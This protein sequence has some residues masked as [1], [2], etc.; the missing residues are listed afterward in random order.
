M[1]IQK[2]SPSLINKIAAGEVVERPASVVKELMEN[3]L[4]A[5]ATR[6]DVAVV[7]GGLE[8]VRV[9]DNGG[10]IA[11]A[12]MPLAV[13]P[14]ATSKLPGEEDLF[15]VRTLG[16]RGE[17]L[18]SIAEVSR[19]VLRSRTPHHDG[20]GELE[21][22]GGQVGQVVPCGCPVG[23]SVEVHN[24]FYNTPVRR[25]FLRT[26]QTEFGHVSEAF[27]RI[28]LA[29]PRVHFTLTHNDRPVFDLAAE[30]APLERIRRFFGSELADNMFWVE[31][32]DGA[33]ELSGYV[34]HPG[35]SRSHNRMQYL[36]LNGRYIRDRSLQHALGEAYRGLLMT[37]RYPIVFLTLTMPPELVDVNVHPTKLEVRFQDSG[38]L[39]SQLLSTLRNRFLTTDLNTRVQ[40]PGDCPNFR[41]ENG[42]VPFGIEATAAGGM[43]PGKATQLKEDLVAWAKGQ[44]AAWD[45]ADGAAAG[46]PSATAGSSSS[47]GS[48]VGQTNRG[49]LSP[50]DAN[51][52]FLT[53]HTVDHSPSAAE[54]RPSPRKNSALQ[55]HNR[56]LVTESEEGVMVIDQHALHERILYEQL[57]ERIDRGTLETQTLL[58]PE[59]VDLSSTEAAAALEHREVLAALGLKIEPF[60][61]ET[62]LIAGYP[63]M[64][65]NL[66]PGE[67]LRL[68]LEPLLTAG[69]TPDRRDLLDEMLHTIAC[70]AAVKAGDRLAPEEI[71]ALL[72][73]RHL[74]HDAHH[75]PHGRPTA[76]IFTREELDRQFKRV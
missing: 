58:V 12:D 72:L 69:K 57:K 19:F 43:D 29:A 41:N 53:L 31:S 10:G 76:L 38:R 25:K 75:C 51:Q 13:A 7:Q 64:L 16:F 54:S 23:T 70:K 47:E 56:Y 17:A 4:D 55:I 48:T 30:D 33:V 28:A 61:G 67:T 42:T 63:A 71:D 1:P 65:A 18:A 40:S 27:T 50:T 52:S 9:V 68:L 36:F 5:G 73:Q 11:T 21:V 6:V 39:Y 59:P 26:T 62:V 44:V 24:L 22:V 49:T 20:G 66:P 14:H 32:A 2:L 46:L 74:A 3:A 60:G 35:Q 37:G 8:L 34:A 15:R 45:V